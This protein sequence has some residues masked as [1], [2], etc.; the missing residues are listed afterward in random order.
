MA[1]DVFQKTPVNRNARKRLFR[2]AR[3]GTR[4]VPETPNIGDAMKAVDVAKAFKD[5][6]EASTADFPVTV[7]GTAP[8]SPGTGTGWAG[9]KDY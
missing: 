1:N 5:G 6:W 4:A 3:L 7:R 8:T 9:R 2:A